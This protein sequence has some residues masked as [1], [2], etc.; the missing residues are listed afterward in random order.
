VPVITSAEKFGFDGSKDALPT[1]N[2]TVGPLGLLFVLIGVST[3]H[4]GPSGHRWVFCQ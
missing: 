4:R 2:C 1:D 3:C